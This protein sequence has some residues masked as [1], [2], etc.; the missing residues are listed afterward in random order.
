M[1]NPHSK[2]VLNLNICSPLKEIF[3]GHHDQNLHNIVMILFKSIPI[4]RVFLVL[5][6]IFIT[7][8]T[9]KNFN[10]RIKMIMSISG[11]M[12]DLKLNLSS[13]HYY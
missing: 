4:L 5:I 1:T 8:I 2:I 9:L 10:A 13:I 11:S 6:I 3:I 7:C 12:E